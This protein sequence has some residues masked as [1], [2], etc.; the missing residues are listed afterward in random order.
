MMQQSIDRTLRALIAGAIIMANLFFGDDSVAA[1]SGHQH[2]DGRTN[3][4]ERSAQGGKLLP[5]QG[6][7]VKILPR[8][9]TRFF[10][11]TK[12]PSSLNSLKESGVI[13]CMPM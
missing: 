4:A 13:M 12:F 1:Q 8:Q 2:Q 10:K 3:R 11:K 5:A 7:S 9:K 6:A